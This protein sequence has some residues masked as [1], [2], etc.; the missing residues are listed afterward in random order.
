MVSEIRIYVEGGGRDTRSRRLIREGFGQFLRPICELAAARGIKWS[1]IPSGSRNAAFENFT[2]ALHKHPD[3]FNVL[4]VDSETRVTRRRWEH[5]RQQ[6]N[7]NIPSV[8]EEHCHLMAQT[9]EAWIL[10][11]PEA[12]IAYYGRG[13]VRSALPK[14]SDIE[15]VAKGDLEKSLN[16]A[17]AK[18]QKGRY[19]KIR[20]CAD[21][22]ALLSPDR[23]RQRAHHC[24]VLF[25]TL[26][27]RIRE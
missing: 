7:W 13:F 11:D 16:R 18:T 12:L 1:L 8:P 2:L 22:L 10:A 5:L 15:A 4:L 19:A 14:H 26:E 27:A 20:H 24:D 6:D 9:V 21:L 17:T 23:V 25:T 3:A